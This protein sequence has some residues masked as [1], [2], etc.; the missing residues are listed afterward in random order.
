ME[1]HLGPRPN[2]K[3]EM[4]KIL[5]FRSMQELIDKTVPKQIREE[6][7]TKMFL[8]DEKHPQI[9]SESEFLKKM[10]SIARENKVFK[11]Y[12]GMGYYPTHTPNVILRNVFEN[13][14]WYTP[15]T[16]YQA[17]IA[18]GRLESLLNFQT[19]V[20]ELTGMPISNA[21]LLD[22]ATAAAE[23]MFMA[24]SITGGRKSTI[25]VSDRIFP[26]TLAVI[27]TRAYPLG[28][29]VEVGNPMSVDFSAREDVFGLIV[30]NPDLYG[31]I[32][33]WTAKGKTV[34][35]KQG[36]F[37]VVQDILSVTRHKT[38]GEMGADIAVGST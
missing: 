1:R 31:E 26:Q 10:K 18:Q 9:N 23:A 20:S 30:Q 37:I 22:E 7:F 34:Q 28:I 35:D 25:Y 17:E 8:N 16:P 5:G 3:T 4:L 27:K 12:Q 33:D 21:S 38:P 11:S 14:N 36:L 6:K 29:N 2:D 32:H 19:M 15:Y 24:H 13:P